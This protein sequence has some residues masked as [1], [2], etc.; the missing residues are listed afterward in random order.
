MA[1]KPNKFSAAAALLRTGDRLLV[2]KQA[3]ADYRL[4]FPKS[5][6]RREPKLAVFPVPER[7][8]VDAVVVW[9]LEPSEFVSQG[10]FQT[11]LP[12]EFLD[13]MLV[14]TDIEVLPG[15][16]WIDTSID[17]V[18]EAMRG[19]AAQTVEGWLRAMQHPEPKSS[20]EEI[21]ETQDALRQAT[22]TLRYR[23][24]V[25]LRIGFASKAEEYLSDLSTQG[26]FVQKLGEE[27]GAAVK[28]VWRQRRREKQDTVKGLRV[29]RSAAVLMEP[30]DSFFLP[31]ELGE[32]CV[33]RL[34]LAIKMEFGGEGA[35]TRRTGGGVRVWRPGPPP[36]TY[37]H[38]DITFLRVQVDKL[39]LPVERGQ[40][41]PPPRGGTETKMPLPP[42]PGVG[43]YV[44]TGPMSDLRSGR[45]ARN[46]H[47]RLL[48]RGY[49]SRVGTNTD[50]QIYVKRTA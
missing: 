6:F 3:M 38:E 49:L 16:T 32:K 31:K 42:L 21:V 15:V 22:E 28:A 36:E 29:W 25:R 2:T 45:V 40:P 9:C 30:G 33:K 1:R 12:S 7:F 11:W 35:I 20:Q 5:V 37:K 19:T 43:E 13:A 23:E 10:V 44:I 8:G 50:D 14:R 27:P 17:A 41:V 48:A 4:A 34:R 24:G 18:A 26:F 46:I 39:T 47:R